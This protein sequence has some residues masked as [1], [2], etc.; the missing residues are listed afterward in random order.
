MVNASIIAAK[1]ADLANRIERAHRHCPATSN[2]LATDVDALDLVSFNLMLA[3]QTCSDIAF[4]IISDEG[5]P[6]ASSLS[7]GFDRLVEHGLTTAETAK[8]LKLAVGLR[9]VVAHGYAHID[10]AIVH[11]AATTG[12]EDLRR[13]AA[14]VA[15]YIGGPSR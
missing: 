6:T 7:A 1:L 2:E 5:W 8:Q 13:F 11:A 3:V 12:I 10:V 4:H 15:R 14:D 9:N